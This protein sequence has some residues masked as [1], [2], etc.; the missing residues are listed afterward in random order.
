MRVVVVVVS[1]CGQAS[2]QA[3]PPSPAVATGRTLLAGLGA[4]SNTAPARYL[5]RQTTNVL[6]GGC[7]TEQPGTEE[8]REMGEWR[9]EESQSHCC[10]NT[11]STN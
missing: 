5:E 10:P 7:Q 2:H 8:R 6:Q 11:T 1:E 4:E 9:G 3:L